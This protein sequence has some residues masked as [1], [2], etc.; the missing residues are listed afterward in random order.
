ML[1]FGVSLP[2]EVDSLDVH[3][4]SFEYGKKKSSSVLAMNCRT[5]EEK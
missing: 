5:K 3:E 4:Y 2:A 1:E